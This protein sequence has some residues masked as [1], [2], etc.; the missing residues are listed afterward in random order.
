[1]GVDQ[2]SSPGGSNRSN[3]KL[4]GIV[5][6]KWAVFN[7]RMMTMLRWIKAGGRGIRET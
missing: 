4:E 5:A 1:V 6:H 2:F 3:R 7:A